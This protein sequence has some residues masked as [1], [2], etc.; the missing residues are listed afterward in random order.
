M[1]NACSILNGIPDWT[2]SLGE[3]GVDGRTVLKRILEE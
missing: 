1:R 2:R 3:V